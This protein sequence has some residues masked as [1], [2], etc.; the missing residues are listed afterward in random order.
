MNIGLIIFNFLFLP[1]HVFPTDDPQRKLSG[2]WKN[3]LK[4]AIHSVQ[5]LIQGNPRRKK[6]IFLYFSY[7]TAYAYALGCVVLATA[8]GRGNHYRNKGEMNDIVLS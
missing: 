1:T 4:S 3:H 8:A 5:V 7:F 2:S 6:T